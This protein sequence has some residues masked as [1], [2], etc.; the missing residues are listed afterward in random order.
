MSACRGT[1]AAASRAGKSTAARSRRPWISL[2]G[3]AR[4]PSGASGIEMNAAAEDLR[5]EA[6]RLRDR[7]RAVSRWKTASASSPPPAPFTDAVSFSCAAR[8]NCFPC[9]LL[10]GDL[11][12]KDVS[13]IDDPTETDGGALS[14]CC[15]NIMLTAQVGRKRS[16]CRLSQRIKR[17][18]S[19]GFRIW[20]GGA[21]I[22]KCRSAATAPA[23]RKGGGERPRGD[24]ALHD[25]RAQRRAKRSP[26]FGRRFRSR[27]FR[28]GSGAYDI[29]TPAARALSLP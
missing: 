29:S 7:M 27:N 8:K 20:P 9:L 26:G 13:L 4:E 24:I 18:L 2:K 3:A 5:F 11:S 25:R 19:A 10:N 12:G 21:C 6:R 1:G 17:T 15:V 23:L 28:T 16:F 14:P 22:S